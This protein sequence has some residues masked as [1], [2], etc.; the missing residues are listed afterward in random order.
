MFTVDQI[1]SA[2]SKVKSGADFPTYIKE[3]KALG[4]THYEAYV[5]DGHINYH[6]T[7]DYTA[8]VPDM[9]E[10]LNNLKTLNLLVEATITETTIGI[11]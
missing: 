7:N 5:S 2:H 6:G 11:L 4:V 9:G 3:I 8:K 1:K 10:A